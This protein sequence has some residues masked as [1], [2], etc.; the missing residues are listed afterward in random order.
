MHNLILSFFFTRGEAS[1]GPEGKAEPGEMLPEAQHLL[2]EPAGFQRE[3]AL[4]AER[5]W[6]LGSRAVRQDV[7]LVLGLHW[8]VV[9]GYAASGNCDIELALPRP[10][11]D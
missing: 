4:L 9:F 11:F 10:H 5:L 7:S 2:R 3:S 1:S 6:A 8:L